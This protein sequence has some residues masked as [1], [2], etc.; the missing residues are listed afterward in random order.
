MEVITSMGEIAERYLVMYV[1]NFLNMGH[2]EV[3]GP[4]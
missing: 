2:F 1:Q 4:R 3:G